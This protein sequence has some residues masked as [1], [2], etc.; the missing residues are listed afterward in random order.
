MEDQQFSSSMRDRQRSW[1]ECSG[2]IVK[3]WL[4]P[5]KECSRWRS[6]KAN[7]A[8]AEERKRADWVSR[9][10]TLTRVDSEHGKEI[11]R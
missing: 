1:I 11:D 2:V 8:S 7:G 4:S 10:S 9:P 5:A 3:E 6:G